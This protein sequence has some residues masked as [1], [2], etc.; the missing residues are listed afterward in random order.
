MNIKRL[1]PAVVAG[2]S[3]FSTS[4]VA[5]GLNLNENYVFNHTT[6]ELTILQSR[7]ARHTELGRRAIAAYCRELKKDGV[8][9]IYVA[10]P[11]SVV[12]G[13]DTTVIP[14]RYERIDCEE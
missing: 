11:D 8:R 12:N 5:S 9:V 6:G 4:I 13:D 14:F 7:A 10:T 2:L 3:I 1:I